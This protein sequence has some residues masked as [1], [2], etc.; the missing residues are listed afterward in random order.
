MQVEGKIKELVFL[1]GQ[2]TA[3]IQCPSLAIPAPGRYVHACPTQ[4]MTPLGHAIFP[5]RSMADGFLAAPAVPESWL[6][7]MRLDLRGPLGH[8]FA[9]PES[10]RRVALIALGE[11]PHRLLSL[12]EMAIKQGAAVTLVCAHPPEDLPLEIEIQPLH[13]LTETWSWADYA[14]LDG[15][16]SSISELRGRS[17]KSLLRKP[18]AL[19]QILIHTW[20][21]CAGLAKCGVCTVEPG[22]E[23]KLSCEDGPVFDL[24][25]GL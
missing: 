11:T 25:L 1:D 18:P 2:P 21:P 20:M 15:D 24:D 17:G 3:Y 8:G 16:R 14:A 22:K 4:G 19:A 9:L 12:V 7:G 5:A 23:S 6:P 13:A 10:A